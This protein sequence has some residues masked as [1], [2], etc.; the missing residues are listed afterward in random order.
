MATAAF[1]VAAANG[2][3]VVGVGMGF[4]RDGCVSLFATVIAR[5]LGPDGVTL[6][7]PIVGAL[8]A[9]PHTRGARMGAQTLDFLRAALVARLADSDSGPGGSCGP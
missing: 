7:G 9:V 2:R 3:A 5:Q 1:D 4:V 6:S 8:L